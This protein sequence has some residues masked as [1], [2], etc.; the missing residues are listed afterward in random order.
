[1]IERLGPFDLDPCAAVNR[2]WDVAKNNYTID[3]DGL[4]KD[5][6]GRVWMN[7]PFGKGIKEWI[8]KLAKHGNGFVLMPLRSTDAR[9]FHDD[10][11]NAAHS[12]M[13]IKGR[14]KY[15]K[16]DGTESGSCP[17]ASIIAAYGKE[18]SNAL[19]RLPLAGKI[20]KLKEAS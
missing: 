15:F 11:W 19:D 12:I 6:D 20:I 14:I 18:N 4:S 1:M 10:I 3:D 7:P 8:N 2:P 13:F 16:I 5:W 17:H 9:W